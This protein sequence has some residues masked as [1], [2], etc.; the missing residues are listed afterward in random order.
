[1][2]GANHQTGEHEQ[3][4]GQCNFGYDKSAEQAAL[5]AAAGSADAAED[6]GES[7]DWRCAMRGESEKRDSD[8]RNADR[9]EQDRD[10]HGDDSFVGDGSRRDDAEGGMQ[11]GVGKG[12]G[13][14]HGD[15]AS[16]SDSVRA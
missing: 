13:Y 9:D 8:E 10:V 6:G 1:M 16:R 3:R 5:R 11:P 14:G 7:T 2:Q 12:Q 15:G 4:Q